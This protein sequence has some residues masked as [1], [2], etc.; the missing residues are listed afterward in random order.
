MVQV[1][2]DAD[3]GFLELFADLGLVFGFTKPATMVVKSHATADLSR[4]R[5]DGTNLVAGCLHF[6][7]LI[8]AGCRVTHGN[9]KLGSHLV[10]FQCFEDFFLPVH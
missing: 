7:C 3:I 2:D 5:G 6:G 9:P 1:V 4:R 8:F 10:A